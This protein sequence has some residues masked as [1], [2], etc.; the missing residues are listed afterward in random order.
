MIDRPLIAVRRAAGGRSPD[1]S[2]R[3][4]GGKPLEFP[5]VQLVL[6]SP[7]GSLSG[8]PGPRAPQANPASKQKVKVGPDRAITVP[9]FSTICFLLYR[10]AHLPSHMADLL[11]SALGRACSP[12]RGSSGR[13]RLR[14]PSLHTVRAIGHSRSCTHLSKMT[15]SRQGSLSWRLATG[16]VVC[17]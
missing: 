16:G 17:V 8:P 9:L 4:I 10:G 1:R 12:T 11:V 14:R 5:F 2:T 15:I 3:R 7:D 6:S 13:H